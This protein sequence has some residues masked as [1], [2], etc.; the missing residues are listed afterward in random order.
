MRIRLGRPPKQAPVAAEADAGRP[1]RQPGPWTSAVLVLLAGMVLLAG[2]IALNFVYSEL[3]P[4]IHPESYDEK[5]IPWA[6]MA[7]VLILCVLAH[8]LL[9]ALL[10][11]DCGR[12]DSTVLFVDWK[13]LGFG[14]YYEG[15]IPR[16]RWIVMRLFPLAALTVLAL[17]GI[18]V[19]D[20]W[21]TF[22]LESYL[23]VLILTNSLGSGADLASVFIVLRQVPAPGVLNFH[24]G[25]AYWL[26]E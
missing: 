25:R 8:E 17:A 18:I 7:V 6:G 1:I 16:A 5:N 21:M 13:R 24:R 22:T 15:R 4:D 20:R 26:P 14:V 2:V 12:S 3:F 10:Y 9:H 11:P 19:L 23:W